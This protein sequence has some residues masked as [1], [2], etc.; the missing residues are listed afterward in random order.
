MTTLTNEK[1]FSLLRSVA[2]VLA[3]DA[4]AER[5]R[6]S[7]TLYDRLQDIEWQKFLDEI[8]HIVHSG[9]MSAKSRV[10][11]IA[12]LVGQLYDPDPED[13]YEDE[14]DEVELGGKTKVDQTAST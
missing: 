4:E 1:Y 12:E 7:E 8:D 5:D 14:S 6:A 3:E 2:K 10:E 11:A 13:D 9:S